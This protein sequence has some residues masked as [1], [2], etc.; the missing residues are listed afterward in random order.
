MSI[1]KLKIREYAQRSLLET[2]CSKLS[3]EEV[4]VLKGGISVSIAVHLVE[5]GAR[6]DSA[7]VFDVLNWHNNQ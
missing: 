6:E 4:R 1:E 5:N 2:I 7:E 3:K